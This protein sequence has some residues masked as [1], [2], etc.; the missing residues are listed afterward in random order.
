MSIPAMRDV[1]DGDRLTIVGTA[2]RNPDY[3]NIITIDFFNETEA[4]NLGNDD[5]LMNVVKVERATWNEVTA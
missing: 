4:F 1:Q 3:P 2:R 5:Y